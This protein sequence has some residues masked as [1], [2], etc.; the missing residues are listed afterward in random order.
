MAFGFLT[1]YVTGCPLLSFNKRN[2]FPRAFVIIL[3]ILG[4]M[5]PVF[6][7]GTSHE[8]DPM[9]YFY[10]TQ[11]IWSSKSLH[12]ILK[13]S[14]M[15][16]L[17]TPL[18]SIL[19]AT[20]SISTLSSHF[21]RGND[22]LF[23]ELVFVSLLTTAFITV[24]DE[25]IRI[26]LF[27]PRPNIQRFINELDDV[28]TATTRLGV[29]FGSLFGDA[30]LVHNVLCPAPL[31][32]IDNPETEEVNRMKELSQQMANHYFCPIDPQIEAPLEEDVLRI[33]LL[34][35]MG[36]LGSN[37]SISEWTID[38]PFALGTQQR[39]LSTVL[40]RGLTVFIASWGDVLARCVAASGGHN[41][42]E[43]AP[44]TVACWRFAITAI[45]RSLTHSM[46]PIGDP[47][48]DWNS[49]HLTTL[50]PSAL[51]ALFHLRSGVFS[52]SK[53]PSPKTMEHAF[54]ARTIERMCDDAA[55]AILLLS[56]R[57]KC[58]SRFDRCL[59]RDCLQWKN[60]LTD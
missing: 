59:D 10:E 11:S 7:E 50:I 57:L 58:L 34:E 4:N 25:T 41:R 19:L 44:A 48:S 36:G 43:M 21:F 53:I 18:P 16:A 2:L 23:L 52:F 1:A 26:K 24:V 9:Q 32:G 60:T 6:W 33:L 8:I 30:S 47:M 54:D 45:Q 28:P 5:A 56:K 12:S 20:S 40:V 13:Q 51:V 15:L 42:W 14:V 29:L 38:H 37:D 22:R 27:H 3:T 39:R 17:M 55:T 49:A 35:S 46:S 31:R